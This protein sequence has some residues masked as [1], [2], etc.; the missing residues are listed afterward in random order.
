MRY[1]RI[2]PAPPISTHALREEGDVLCRLKHDEYNG[3]ST[4]ALRE[5]GDLLYRDFRKEII[6]F[7]PR[8]PRGG[9]PATPPGTRQGRNNFYPRPPRGGRHQDYLE[10]LA[11]AGN[12]YPRPPRGGRPA[13]AGDRAGA[14]QFLPTPSARRATG[15]RYTTKTQEVFLPTPSARRATAVWEGDRREV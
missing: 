5:E 14:D 10:A 2:R 12:F 11:E 4:H 15:K 7:Y 9:R 3:I 1:T 8:P 6:Y 13:G